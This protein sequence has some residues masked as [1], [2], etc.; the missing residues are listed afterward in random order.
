MSTLTRYKNYN[1]FVDESRNYDIT[2]SQ[3]TLAAGFAGI[4]ENPLEQAKN[5][6]DRDFLTNALIEIRKL[7]ATKR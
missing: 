1:I 3:H 6:I 2:Q 4:D 5:L 7:P